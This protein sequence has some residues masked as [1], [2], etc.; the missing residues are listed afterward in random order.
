MGLRKESLGYDTG[1]L[2]VD[3]EQNSVA[4]PNNGKLGGADLKIMARKCLFPKFESGN[5]KNS[6][7]MDKFVFS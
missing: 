4:R 5:L 6:R 1:P 7:G 2:P 3:T